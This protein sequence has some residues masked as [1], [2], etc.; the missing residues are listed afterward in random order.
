MT[1]VAISR[2]SSI[3][4]SF[5]G[6]GGSGNRRV[7]PASSSRRSTTTALVTKAIATAKTVQTISRRVKVVGFTMQYSGRPAPCPYGRP[8]VMDDGSHFP[9]IGP[10]RAGSVIVARRP[11]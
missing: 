2:A 9:A 11:L 5:G 1:M 8:L 4:N 7:L 3:R 6:K 10:V